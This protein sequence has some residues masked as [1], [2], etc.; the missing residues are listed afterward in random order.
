MRHSFTVRTPLGDTHCTVEI[1]DEA[2]HFESDDP[3]SGGVE[4]LRWESIKEGGTAAISGM[5]GRGGPE[6]PNWV[7]TQLE[8]LGLSRTPGAGKPLMRA[9]PA[10]AARDSIVAA[11]RQR[12]GS[13][14]IGER[15]PL[16]DAQSRL[17]VSSSDGSGLKVA[18]IIVAVLALLALLIILLVWVLQIFWIPAGFFTGGWLFRKGLNGLRDGLAVANTPTAKSSSA[19]LGLVELQGRARTI[20]RRHRPASLGGRVSGGMWLSVSGTTTVATAVNG[21]RWLR[22]M[23]A[24]SMSWNSKTTAGIFRYGSKARI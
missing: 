24:A 9:L 8:W 20:R 5:G 21:D 1:G 15:M 7:P 16:Q 11:V 4:T 22:A 18:G 10:G 23:V 3:F 17:G 14:W 12:L 2:L 6:L 13:R 19:A